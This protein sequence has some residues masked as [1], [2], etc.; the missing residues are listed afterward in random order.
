LKNWISPIENFS[1]LKLYWVQEAHLVEA[2]SFQKKPTFFET[3]LIPWVLFTINTWNFCW[4]KFIAVMGP[5]QKNLTQVGKGQ[6]L[7]A[8]VGSG[9]PSMV[10]IWIWKISPKNINFFTF[11]SKKISSGQVKKYPGHSRVGLLFTVC[12]GRVRVHH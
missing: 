7:V 8:H 5:D 1:L 9:Q 4:T 10:W 6:F 11:G 2:E 3:A 12:S